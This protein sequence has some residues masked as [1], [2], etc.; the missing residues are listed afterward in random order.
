M[1]YSRTNPSPRYA[2]L[3]NYS[4]EMH[5]NGH[6]R[7]IGCWK[8]RAEIRALV[9]ETDTRTLLDYGC[10]DGLQF[11]AHDSE[12]LFSKLSVYVESWAEALGVD[13]VSGYDPA[14]EP[15]AAFPTCTFDG[16]YCA[17]VL[18]HCAE[19]DIPWI[20]EELFALATKFLFVTIALIPAKKNLPN[21]ENVHATLKPK[22]WWLGHFE[23]AAA[24]H[25][26]V[27][28]RVVFEEGN[29]K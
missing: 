2:T 26:M 13:R 10:G 15:Y 24:V 23:R 22:A 12:K 16:V 28:W 1:T 3:V 14:C 17:D 11:E 7:G 25:P 9:R 8:W 21:G 5:D 18:E 29:S 19:E 4:K 6:F 27:R 20:V